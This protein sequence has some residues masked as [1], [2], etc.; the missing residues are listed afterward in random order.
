MMS[1]LNHLF[2]AEKIIY[3]IKHIRNGGDN[4]MKA[5]PSIQWSLIYHIKPP[6]LIG[7]VWVILEK[8]KK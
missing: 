8:T 3:V 5:C 1:K 6:N 2:N 4:V 7:L